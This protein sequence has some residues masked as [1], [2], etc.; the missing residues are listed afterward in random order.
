VQVKVRESF[1]LISPMEEEE[2]VE[3]SEGT[4][5]EDE[6]ESEPEPDSEARLGKVVEKLDRGM[7]VLGKKNGLE[8]IEI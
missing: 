1:G 6:E 3:P 4:D 7:K 5:T 2:E 8:A